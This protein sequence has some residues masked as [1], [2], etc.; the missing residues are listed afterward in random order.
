MRFLVFLVAVLSAT[1]LTVSCVTGGSCFNPQP[2]PPGAGC[3][4]DEGEGGAST[5]TA[6]G[7]GGLDGGSDAATGD[8]GPA[9]GGEADGH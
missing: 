1:I 8:G 2:D 5:T 9:D 3:T 4:P 7:T 6:T